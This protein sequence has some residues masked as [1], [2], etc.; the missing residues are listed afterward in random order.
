[1]TPGRSIALGAAAATLLAA[2]YLVVERGGL[3]AWIGV[4]LA[5]LLL[6][7]ML[8]RPA[9]RDMVLAV[10]TLTV[11]ILAWPVT[12]YYVMSTWE[13]GEV[14]DVETAGGHTAR[15]WVLDMSDGPTMYYD[16]PPDIARNL[17]AGT[18]VS[19]TR[20]GRVQQ[21]CV[22]ASRVEDISNERLQDLYSEMEQ[23]YQGLNQATEVFY[24]VLGGERDRIGVLM[25]LG[26][27]R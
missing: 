21:G 15:V 8:S 26:P 14:V 6:I 24:T 22:A 7:K 25:K 4:V 13:S 16:A 9:R 12:W 27:C 10:S 5:A 3:L 17:L 18:P 11:W 1:M 19:V 23:K 20:A 2:A